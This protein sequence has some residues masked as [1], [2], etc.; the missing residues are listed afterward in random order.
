MMGKPLKIIASLK[1]LRGTIA[2]GVAFFLAYIASNFLELS[3]PYLANQFLIR[4]DPF[5]QITSTFFEL[6]TQNQ[7]LAISILALFIA[8]LRYVEAF[9]IWS[10][11]KWASWLIIAT[12]FIYIPFE[13][14][15]LIVGFN[16]AMTLVLVI[17]LF[18]VAYLLYKEFS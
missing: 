1:I 8:I 3:E 7:V 16:W 9:G 12:G 6:V 17:N 14:Y 2:L 4:N 10:D 15:F 5:L 13:A 18:V 11:K